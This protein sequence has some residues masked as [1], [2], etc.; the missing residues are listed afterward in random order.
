MLYTFVSTLPHVYTIAYLQVFII[1]WK[2]L[3][4]YR[5]VS[6]CYILLT[7]SY[8]ER[9]RPLLTSHEFDYSYL[10][11][12]RMSWFL[13]FHTDIVTS[14]R[15][16]CCPLFPLPES[17]I[18]NW[19][20]Y[21]HR[22]IASYIHIFMFTYLHIYI[23]TFYPHFIFSHHSTRLFL[24]TLEQFYRKTPLPFWFVIFTLEGSSG[25]LSQGLKEEYV[26]IFVSTLS[27]VYI[28]A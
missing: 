24:G 19:T 1:S 23:H 5:L 28:F 2:Q 26:Y 13:L 17:A 3:F 27:H 18:L 6:I 12:S 8:G 14:F 21:L 9:Y 25:V 16:M 20:S 10:H 4:I 22:Y 15:L 11:I 7:G